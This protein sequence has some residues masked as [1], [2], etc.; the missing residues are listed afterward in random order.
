MFRKNKHTKI[1]Q[2]ALLTRTQIIYYFPLGQTKVKKNST[3]EMI[4]MDNDFELQ[5][6]FSMN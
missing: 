4:K 6:T 5:S 2:L 3:T 1:N